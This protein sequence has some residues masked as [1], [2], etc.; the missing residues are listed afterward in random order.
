MANTGPFKSLEMPAMQAM[1]FQERLDS[2]KTPEGL[3]H[4]YACTLNND[5]WQQNFRSSFYS[6][7]TMN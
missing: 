6:N 1:V 5:Q 4:I 3:T 2:S 7:K